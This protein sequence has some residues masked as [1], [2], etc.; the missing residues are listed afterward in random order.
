MKFLVFGC[1]GMAGHTISLY[2]REQGYMVDGFARTKSRFVPTVI[3]DAKDIGRVREA[4][5]T[6]DYDAVINCIGILNDFAEKDQEAATYFNAYFPHLLEKLTKDKETVVVHISTDCVFSGARGGYTEQDFPDGKTF[7]DR[8]K[9]LGELKNEKD[10]TIRC[11]IVGPDMNT[12]GI[13]LLNWFLQQKG[14]V[15]GYAQ[16]FWTGQTALQL[17]KTIEEAVRVQAAGLYNMV[18]VTRI[19]KYELLGLFNRFLRKKQIHIER[20]ETFKV[21]KSLKRT[22]Y[23]GMNYAV[24]D[25]ETQIRELGDWMRE[26]QDLYPHY[27]L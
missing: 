7:Y 2:L 13:G 5:D 21:D 4:V 23:E 14:E 8:S 3:G 9:A 1:N 24:P 17:A 12:K 27:E 26:H 25:Y 18:P 20:D 11:S 19:S 16:V 22:N 15:K 6:S 10:I